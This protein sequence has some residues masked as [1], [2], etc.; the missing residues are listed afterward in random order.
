MKWTSEQKLS[1]AKAFMDG[2]F[3]PVPE[4]LSRSIARWHDRVREWARVLSEYG[5]EGLNPSRRKR[6]FPPEAKL[7][8]VKR[9]LAGESACAVAFSLGMPS[10]SAVLAWVRAYREKGADGLESRPKGRKTHAQ[11]ETQIPGAGRIGEAQ[12][13]E[14]HAGPRDCLLKKIEGL[15]GAGGAKP[16][17]KCEAILQ[18]KKEFPEARLSDL[19]AVAGLPKSTYF[20]EAGRRDSAA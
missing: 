16:R 19:L 20:Y 11:E 3:V 15:G 12:A 9:V 13:G 8:A 17:Q 4:G 10:H 5:E 6:S 7:A 2:E 18:I 14:L 1:W